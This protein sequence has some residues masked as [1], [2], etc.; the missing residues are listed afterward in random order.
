MSEFELKTGDLYFTILIE[1][2]MNQKTEEKTY[3][4]NHIE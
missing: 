4:T 3:F 2:F 1:V